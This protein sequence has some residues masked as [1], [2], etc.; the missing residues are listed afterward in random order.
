M[1]RKSVRKTGVSAFAVTARQQNASARTFERPVYSTDDRI[2][3]AGAIQ[4]PVGFPASTD[5][6]AQN[7][8]R[9]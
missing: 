4:E 9:N 7:L 3:G 2:R 5:M 6:T 1:K 8:T